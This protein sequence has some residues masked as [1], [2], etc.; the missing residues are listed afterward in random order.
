M[1]EII[2]GTRKIRY[3][4]KYSNRCKNIQLRLTTPDNVEVTV[5]NGHRKLNMNIEQMLK[6]KAS[7]ITKQSSRLLLLQQNPVNKFLTQGSYLLYLGKQYCITYTESMYPRVSIDRQSISVSLPYP[8][9]LQVASVILRSWYIRMA[10]DVLAQKTSFWASQLGVKPSKIKIKDQKTRWGSCSSHSNI[11]YN[12]RIIM[13]P[14]SVVDYLVVH[15]LCHMIVPNHSDR[16]WKLV[17]KFS[18][19][20]KQHRQWLNN[21]GSLLMRIL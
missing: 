17:A 5:P 2:L 14:E 9:N 21:N 12:W 13:A 19:C 15:E 7:W 8:V 20:F 16:F 4:I 6:D 3:T 10:T 18:P 11:N 1:A